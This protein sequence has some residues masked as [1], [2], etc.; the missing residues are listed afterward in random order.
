[1]P[2]CEQRLARVSVGHGT[3]I[4]Q[5]NADGSRM[6]GN[7]RLNQ[8]DAIFPL[9]SLNM[10]AGQFLRALCHGSLQYCEHFWKQKQP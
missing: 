2:G 4:A 3:D 10:G 5:V 6:S 9:V 7:E 8:I 1:M